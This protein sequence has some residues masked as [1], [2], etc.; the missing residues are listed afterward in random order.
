LHDLFD[1]GREVASYRTAEDCAQT[2][3]RYLGDTE[4]R[5]AM[6]AAGQA[7]TLRDHTYRVRMQ[8]FLEIVH[9]RMAA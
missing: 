8:E 5:Q 1:V 2:I 9:K 4:A 3:R 6:A 7:R